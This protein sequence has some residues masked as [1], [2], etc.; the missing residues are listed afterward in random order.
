MNDERTTTESQ[1][2]DSNDNVRP[3]YLDGETYRE[4]IDFQVLLDF[5]MEDT[6]E[7]EM[8][9]DFLP[10]SKDPE[11]GKPFYMWVGTCQA[12]TVSKDYLDGTPFVLSSSEVLEQM[13]KK[14]LDVARERLRE[15][16]E[17]SIRKFERRYMATE[18]E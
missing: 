16:L 18:S 11:T 3:L 15:R 5:L 8:Q 17:Y 10:K 13:R 7:Y 6:F 9:L 14:W 1:A 12:A 2:H 4:V